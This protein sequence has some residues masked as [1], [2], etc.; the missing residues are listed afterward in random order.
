[1]VTNSQQTSARVRV[2]IV[3]FEHEHAYHLQGKRG[4]GGGGGDNLFIKVFGAT[5][6]KKPHKGGGGGYMRACFPP[7]FF[8]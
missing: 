5:N 6:C 2:R 8:V 7:I 1:M 3:V 4:G